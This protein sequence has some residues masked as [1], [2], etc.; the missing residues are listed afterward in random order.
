MKKVV[1]CLI[2]LLLFV[3]TIF[4]IY[5][6]VKYYQSYSAEEVKV[7]YDNGYNEGI[8]NKEELLEQ[9]D[10]FII[11]VEDNK[12]T[13]NNLTKQVEDLTKQL[14]NSQSINEEN[15]KL[16]EDYKIQ[17]QNLETNLESLNEQLDIAIKQN[18]VYNTQISR[19][20]ENISDLNTTI[21]ELN[22]KIKY[23]EELIASY[24]FEDKSIITFKVNNSNYDVIVC[25]KGQPFNAEVE[26]PLFIGNTFVGWSIDGITPITLEGYVFNEDT[27][28]VPIVSEEEQIIYNMS[29]A[30]SYYTYYLNDKMMTT[31]P[32]IS[33]T[34]VFN[35]QGSNI[36]SIKFYLQGSSSMQFDSLIERPLLFSQYGINDLKDFAS[37]NDNKLI[38]EIPMSYMQ[39][40]LEGNYYSDTYLKMTYEIVNNEFTLTD[41]YIS[42][43]IAENSEGFIYSYSEIKSS[44]QYLPNTNVDKEYTVKFEDGLIPRTEVAEGKLIINNNDCSFEFIEVLDEDYYIDEECIQTV[45]E[46]GLDGTYYIGLELKST[47]TNKIVDFY[48]AQFYINLATSSVEVINIFTWPYT[49][50][51]TE[52]I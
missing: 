52:I 38:I 11:I 2:I 7:A 51:Y 15:L 48:M 49:T 29:S 41:F 17:V 4:G 18:N 10:N 19:L 26:E 35:L 30:S 40:Y 24:N 14:E 36:N 33:A 50:T 1:G 42:T 39:D 5:F 23:Y 27:T 8:S 43:S 32:S 31:G 34:S 37:I 28:L 9:I 46:Q 25:E 16:I 47:K 12:V 3:G 45:T 21:S 6:C 22:E 44:I 20:E 13:I